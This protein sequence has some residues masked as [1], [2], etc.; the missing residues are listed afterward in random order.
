MLAG[1][2]SGHYPTHLPDQ[3][4]SH[5]SEETNGVMGFQLVLFTA[6]L[7]T[8]EVTQGVS[9][10]KRP[11]RWGVERVVCLFVPSCTNRSPP[12]FPLSGVRQGVGCIAILP[13]THLHIKSPPNLMRSNMGCLSKAEERRYLRRCLPAVSLLSHHCAAPFTPLPSE[14]RTSSLHTSTCPLLTSQCWHRL[15]LCCVP[16]VVGGSQLLPTD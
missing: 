1:S 16:S 14:P 10:Q 15:Q 11:H 9:S 13:A 2:S 4:W 7:R 12:R 5:S 8:L 3:V 6:N